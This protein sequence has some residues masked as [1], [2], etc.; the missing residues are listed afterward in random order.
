[1][2]NMASLYMDQGRYDEAEPLHV[3]ALELRRRVLGEEHPDTLAA[4]GESLL[5]SS[6]IVSGGF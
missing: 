5:D 1:M 3:E 2:N 4:R 6:V